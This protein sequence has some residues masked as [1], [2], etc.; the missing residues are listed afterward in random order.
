MRTSEVDPAYRSATQLVAALKRREHSAVELLEQ[1]IQRIERH[2][3]RINAIVV[4][5]F[6]RARVAAEESDRLLNRVIIGHFSA[7]PLR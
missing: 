6:E 7:Y 3:R 1:T 4:R 2:D 5:D